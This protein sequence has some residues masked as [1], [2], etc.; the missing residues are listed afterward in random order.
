MSKPV[1]DLIMKAYRDKFAGVN[2]AL[3]VDIRGVDANQNRTLRSTLAAKKIRITVVKNHLAKRVFSGSGLA[4]LNELIEGPTAV[5]YGADSVVS[6]AREIM[7]QAKKIEKLQVKGAVMEGTVFGAAEVERLSKFP[8]R[9]EAQAQVIQVFLGP[10][11]HV[12]GAIDSAGGQ[13]AGVLKTLIEKL[14]KGET[15]AKVA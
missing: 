14:E 13:I 12:L 1:K 4:P 3:L 7:D 10:A 15:V 9:Q 2:D 8:T 5:V 6:V 11:G